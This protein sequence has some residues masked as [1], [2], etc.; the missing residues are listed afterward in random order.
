M[1]IENLLNAA[2]VAGQDRARPLASNFKV[3][4]AFQFS[5]GEVVSGGNTEDRGKT[6]VGACAERNVLGAAN[7]VMGPLSE[8]GSGGTVGWDRAAV[9]ANTP[10]PITP[11]GIC[12]DFMA[13][14]ATEIQSEVLS[15]C[16]GPLRATFTIG[17]LLPL[18]GRGP[19]GDVKDEIEM[20][21]LNGGKIFDIES[22]ESEPL[23]RRAM[24]IA[25]RSYRPPF[26]SEPLAGAA[27]LTEDGTIHEGALVIDATT[28][29]GGTAI[30]MAVRNA[31]VG[32]VGTTS[33]VVAVGLFTEGDIVRAP[34]G[35]DLQLLQEI[36]AKHGDVDV[37]FGC[38]TRAFKTTLDALLPHPF[39][40]ND[41]GY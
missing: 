5:N 26:S 30:S 3:G 39:G 23:I 17:E 1:N 6:V 14:T 34:T 20:W 35:C 8:Y 7:N 24:G 21:R 32:P 10:G 4:A 13:A 25:E 40:R 41:L 18:A 36:R 31:L 11:C 38:N 2:K 28:R 33:R 22:S 29:L 15:Q 9:W 16:E 27:L 37:M 19:G 12:R